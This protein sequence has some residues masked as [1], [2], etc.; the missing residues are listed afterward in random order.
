MRIRDRL[1]MIISDNGEP[2]RS[3]DSLEYPLLLFQTSK[4]ATYEGT[5]HNVLSRREDQ[6]Q[7]S[8]RR[9]DL[10]KRS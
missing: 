7:R 9:I 6:K 1:G 8:S 5:L 3:W 4:L 10:S 2:A